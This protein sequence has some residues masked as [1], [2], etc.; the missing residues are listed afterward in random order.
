MPKLHTGPL[1][2]FLEEGCLACHADSAD[3]VSPWKAKEPWLS[4]KGQG[5]SVIP[6][7]PQ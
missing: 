7:M 4:G 3:A 5:Q 6:Q 1:L 2:V